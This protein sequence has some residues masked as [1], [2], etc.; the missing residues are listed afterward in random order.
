MG[1]YLLGSSECLLLNTPCPQWWTEGTISEELQRWAYCWMEV[2]CIIAASHSAVAKDPE[3]TLLILQ[4]PS[5]LHDRLIIDQRGSKMLRLNQRQGNLLK[6]K[7]PLKWTEANTFI[8]REQSRRMKSWSDQTWHSV[9]LKSCQVPARNEH[10]HEI[11]FM[12]IIQP[13]KVI[14]WD[15][16]TT[17]FSTDPL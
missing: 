4:I 1:W 8:E 16:E 7:K 14:H 5:D 3:Y 10:G 9:T 12:G 6:F 11:A 13:L 17:Q 15:T 2:C